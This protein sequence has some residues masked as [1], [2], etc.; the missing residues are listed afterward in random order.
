MNVAGH[1]PNELWQK[2]PDSNGKGYQMWSQGHVG[3]V[4]IMQNGRAANIGRC[5]VCGGAAKLDCQACKGQGKQVCQICSGKK[6]VPATWTATDNPWLNSQPDLVRLKDGRVFLGRI[7]LS[8]GEQRT[9]VTRDGKAIRV[10]ASD[11]L[12]RTGQ[13]VAQGKSASG[14]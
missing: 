13:G 3:E 14:S 6:F 10:E 1:D 8:M 9:I 5:K 7:A 12:P 11:I 2:F 4:I